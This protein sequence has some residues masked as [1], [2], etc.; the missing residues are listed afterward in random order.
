MLQ[1]DY[2]RE[3]PRAHRLAECIR[4]QLVAL[5]RKNSIALGVPMETRVKE[6]ASIESKI[7]RKALSL[8]RMSDLQDLVGLRMILLFRPDLLRLD[9]LIRTSF[10]IIS[11]EDTAGRLGDSQFGYQ[12]QHYIVKILPSWL[13]VPSYADLG[14]LMAEIQVR[15]LS[16]HIWAAAS[17]ILQYKREESVPPP[18][19]RTIYRVSALLETVDLEFERVLAERVSYVE[20]EIGQLEPNAKLNVDLLRSIAEA[21]LPAANADEEGEEEFDKVL[22]KMNELGV[23]NAGDLRDLLSK[24]M[25]FMIDYDKDLV[26]RHGDSY[27]DRKAR[28]VYLNYTGLI[29][30]MLRKEFGG[31]E[32]DGISID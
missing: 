3:A 6:W 32:M 26:S 2:E 15:T 17:H 31:K 11:V 21:I 4:D 22:Q 14:D 18:L 24:H 10:E 30:N 8:N 28:G 25:K 13:E 1:A 23:E 29:R 12:S 7:E 16:Q 5:L 9:T 20:N 27:P 19:R